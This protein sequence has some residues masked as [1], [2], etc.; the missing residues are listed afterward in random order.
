MA[1]AFLKIF[2]ATLI[3]FLQVV[4]AAPAFRIRQDDPGKADPPHGVACPP[5]C[6]FLNDESKRH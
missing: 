2:A 6:H 5:H 1:S 4:A 3:I